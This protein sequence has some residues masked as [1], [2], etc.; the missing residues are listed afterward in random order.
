MP[1]WFYWWSIFAAAVL[2][3]LVVCGAREWRIARRDR[4]RREAY[5]GRQAPF[6]V[7]PSQVVWHAQEDPV[8]DDGTAWRDDP[9]PQGPAL[10]NDGH[11]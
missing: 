6:K 3:W 7:E 1:S 10:R 2:L 11:W 5:A 9:K 4:K 8:I